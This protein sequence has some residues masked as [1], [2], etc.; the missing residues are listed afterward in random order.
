MELNTYIFY[1]IL[2][3]GL[4]MLW[5]W[6]WGREGKIL[7]FL[8]SIVWIFIF[9]A[10]FGDSPGGRSPSLWFIVDG[11]VL[12]VVEGDFSFERVFEALGK[13]EDKVEEFAIN[14]VVISNDDQSVANNNSDSGS[15]VREERESG[16]DHAKKETQK[17]RQI[18]EERKKE[19]KEKEMKQELDRE[20]KRLDW[21]Q[22][23]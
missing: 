22:L 11:V 20:K 3:I 13:A 9:F 7:G 5:S 12:D 14:N 16:D 19:S 18:I 21:N 2:L 17:I 10:D 23:S 15:A 8:S 6:R 4:K 1:R